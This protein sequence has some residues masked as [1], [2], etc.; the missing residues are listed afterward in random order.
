M[1]DKNTRLDRE[2]QT[3]PVMAF[4]LVVDEGSDPPIMDVL[5]IK[6]SEAT[7]IVDPHLGVQVV[8]DGSSNLQKLVERYLAKGRAGHKPPVESPL[9]TAEMM[10]SDL[11]ATCASSV[12]DYLASTY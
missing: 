1:Y 9:V 11:L 10:Q 3:D 6:S 2:G 8:E 5:G 4:F 12:H 7:Q